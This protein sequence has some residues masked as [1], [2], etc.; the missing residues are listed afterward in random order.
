MAEETFDGQYFSEI[1]MR[2]KDLE[3]K[4]RIIKDRTLI[5]GNNLLEMKDQLR[6]T[7]TEIK[8]EVGILKKDSER[9]KSFL[10]T[11]SDEFS[12]F[13]RKEELNI[14]IKQAKMFQ[15]LELVTKKDLE[16]L[17]NK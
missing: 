11:I 4:Q 2:L 3:E 17:K 16:R 5:I 1:S 10:E 13:A 6:E 9:I 12:K 15:P 14:L 8:K 7:I